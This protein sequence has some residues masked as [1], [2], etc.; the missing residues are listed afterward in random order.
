[1]KALDLIGDKEGKAGRLD[2]YQ[3]LWSTR[4]TE[5]KA[6]REDSGEVV[7]LYIR[8]CLSSQD[9]CL[10]VQHSGYCLVFASQS[11]LVLRSCSS[12]EVFD[13]GFLCKC[14]F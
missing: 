3:D 10:H 11:P 14:G 13:Q 12:R 6:E 8:Q 7:D 1:M 9:L 5:G 2:K 4:D